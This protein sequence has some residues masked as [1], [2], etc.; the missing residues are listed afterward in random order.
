MNAIVNELMTN[1]CE[2][3]A[4]DGLKLEHNTITNTAQ[5]LTWS[6]S[7]NCNLVLFVFYIVNTV[8]LTVI[9]Q[10]LYRCDMLSG[11]HVYGILQ[12]W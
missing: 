2:K 8:R 9:K 12:T 3:R 4:C 10:A 6:E 5:C 1:F 7:R 11:T